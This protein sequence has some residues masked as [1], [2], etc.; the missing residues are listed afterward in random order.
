MNEANVFRRATH[1]SILFSVEGSV[2]T[3]VMRNGLSEQVFQSDC[4]SY[5]A[6]VEEQNKCIFEAVLRGFRASA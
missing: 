4:A 2:L 3:V 6:A 5:M 1:E